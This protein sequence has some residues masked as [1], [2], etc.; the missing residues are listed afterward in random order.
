MK[1]QEHEPV[2]DERKSKS[3]D[4][5]NP[6]EVAGAPLSPSPRSDAPARRVSPWWWSL[7]LLLQLQLTFDLSSLS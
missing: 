1:D 7:A 6:G 2:E 5:W 3:Q 4:C